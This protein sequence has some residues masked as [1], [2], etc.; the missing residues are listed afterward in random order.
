MVQSCI[1]P[2]TV[3]L[4]R[5][6][7]VCISPTKI[8]NDGVSIDSPIFRDGH[9]VGDVIIKMAT[10]IKIASSDAY[11]SFEMKKCTSFILSVFF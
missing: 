5:I 4:N 6:L 11:K 2:V 10:T 1:C 9:G 7:D 3:K 8:K